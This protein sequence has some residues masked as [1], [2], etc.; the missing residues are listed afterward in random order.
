M[1]KEILEVLK[2]IDKKLDKLI[3]TNERSENGLAQIIARLEQVRDY[4]KYLTRLLP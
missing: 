1:N 4:T 3:Y 2:S